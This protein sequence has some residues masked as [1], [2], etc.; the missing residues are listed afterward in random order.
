MVGDENVSSV[1]QIYSSFILLPLTIFQ[2]NSF[3]KKASFL[4]TNTL[5]SLGYLQISTYQI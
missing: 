3:S 2:R 5:V 4:A 1:S